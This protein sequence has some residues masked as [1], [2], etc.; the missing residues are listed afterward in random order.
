MQ[1]IASRYSDLDHFACGAQKKKLKV[2]IDFAYCVFTPVNK[3]YS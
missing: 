3:H 2:C 1:R